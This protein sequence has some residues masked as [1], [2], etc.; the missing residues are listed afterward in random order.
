MAKA[1]VQS[2]REVHSVLAAG[3]ADPELL[4]NWCSDP[5][6]AAT[7]SAHAA[8][9]DF[10]QV[11]RFSGLVTK[12]RYSDLRSN[13][14]ATFRL[15]DGAGLSIELFASYA[16]RAAALSKAGL[17]SKSDKLAALLEF[18]NGWLVLE[19]P[20]HALVWDVIR[21]EGA[22]FQIQTNAGRSGRPAVIAEVTRD[23]TPVRSAGAVMHCM[24]CNP[25]EAVRVVRTHGSLDSIPREPAVYAYCATVREGQIRIIGIDELCAFL[26]EAADGT[27]TIAEL[28]ERLRESGVDLETEELIDAV[29]GLVRA[30]LLE[31]TEGSEACG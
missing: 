30:G 25:V 11:R 23:S 7:L 26:M 24:T 12:V 27:G 4:E 10:E 8:E 21:H 5:S 28:A 31:S 15:L 6:T 22:I 1:R 16:P 20:V 2:A 18:L 14:P 13:F 3:M 19:D 9:I 17:N 29:R